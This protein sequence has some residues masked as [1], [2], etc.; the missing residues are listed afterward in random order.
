MPISK[1]TT[2]TH[3]FEHI[4]YSNVIIKFMWWGVCAYAWYR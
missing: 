2:K 4:V 1:K 3:C